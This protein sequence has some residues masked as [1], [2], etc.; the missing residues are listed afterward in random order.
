MPRAHEGS[1]AR[2]PR[3]V[4]RVWG[5]GA[6]PG[7]ARR[8]VPMAHEGVL[9]TCCL[10]AGASCAHVTQAQTHPDHGETALFM[11]QRAVCVLLLVQTDAPAV[12]VNSTRSH[13][14]VHGTEP[15]GPSQNDI[16]CQM[17]EHRE[18]PHFTPHRPDAAPGHTATQLLVHSL[19]AQPP[20][21]HV[22]G[23]TLC[24]PVVP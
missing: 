4:V 18:P 20:R 23:P 22:V 10:W 8:L 7:P 6:C 24:L 11:L 9:S 2:G 14:T 21:H 5:D 12:V 15:S 17:T 19:A 13:S 16:R 3:R 1:G